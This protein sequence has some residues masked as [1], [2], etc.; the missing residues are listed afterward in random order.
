[1][2]RNFLLSL[3]GLA[4][5]SQVVQAQDSSTP[6]TGFRRPYIPMYGAN[7]GVQSLLSSESRKLFGNNSI[8]FSPG[9]GPAFTKQGLSIQP[10][11]SVFSAKHEVNGQENK[12]FIISL[13]PN[14]RYGLVK[15]LDVEMVDGEPKARFRAFAP[16]VEA[17]INLVYADL[18]IRSEGIS[19]RQFTVGGS[20][21]IGTSITKNAFLKLKVQVVPKIKSYDFSTAGVEFGVRF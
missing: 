13:G 11:V 4:L 16:F 3:I 9:F 7:V 17:G 18:S 14:F 6:P 19:K 2:Q 12:A 15:P 20:F 8:S 10:G 1:M 5:L 21:A